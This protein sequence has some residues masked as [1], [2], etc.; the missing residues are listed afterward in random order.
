LGKIELQIILVLDMVICSVLLH[1]MVIAKK[2]IDMDNTINSLAKE[3]KV[4]QL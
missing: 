4:E 1:N 2:E 3:T